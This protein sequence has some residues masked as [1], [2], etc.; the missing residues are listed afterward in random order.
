[1]VA[2][3]CPAEQK[4]HGVA[5]PPPPFHP[6]LDWGVVGPCLLDLALVNRVRVWSLS[7]SS[8]RRDIMCFGLVCGPKTQ[9]APSHRFSAHRAKKKRRPSCHAQHATARLP[10]VFRR[11]VR[12]VPIKAHAALGVWRGEVDT[13]PA[14]G[15]S[16]Q[17]SRFKLHNEYRVSLMSREGRLLVP[18]NPYQKFERSHRENSRCPGPPFLFSGSKAL[19]LR[20][21]AR[22]DRR[23]VASWGVPPPW[24]RRRGE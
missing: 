22:A 15:P 16:A 11:P 20:P 24:G 18:Q 13:Q 9:M 7:I 3:L 14:V 8:R 17:P 21:V 1:M 19:L 6:A 12:S 23:V 4:S 10:L 5:L 2:F